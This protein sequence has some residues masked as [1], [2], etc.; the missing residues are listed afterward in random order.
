MVFVILVLFE[1][2]EHGMNQ[3]YCARIHYFTLQP[4][5]MSLNY[6]GG[7]HDGNAMSDT[8]LAKERVNDEMSS[9]NTT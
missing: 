4:F 5:P 8:V 3:T 2:A 7:M 6:P 1:S 9:E